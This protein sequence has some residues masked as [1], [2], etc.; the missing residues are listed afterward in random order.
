MFLNSEKS[1]RFVGGPLTAPRDPLPGTFGTNAG[2][3][4]GVV[5]KHAVLNHCRNVC[6]APWFGSHK[7]FGRATVNGGAMIPS[8]AG[9]QFE[10]DGENGNPLCKVT[11]PEISQPP[12]V[13]PTQSFRF[14]KSG[15]S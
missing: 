9:S 4:F 11:M 10:V 6:G 14:A 13:F 12:S 2:I 8:P 5:W 1:T 15:M 3:G 7:T